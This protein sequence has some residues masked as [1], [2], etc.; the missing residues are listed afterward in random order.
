E[1][2]AKKITFEEFL[3]MLQAAANNKE[4]G[5]FE[6]F[7]EGLRVFDKEGN[8]TVMGA[9]LRHVLATL[10]EKMTEEEVD[11][12]MKGQEDS[13]GCIN[14]EGRCKSSTPT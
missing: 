10:G 2:N 14:Y 1:M 8:G 9:E 5:T 13:N 12:L 11:E 6:D 3:P 4:Q 7:V